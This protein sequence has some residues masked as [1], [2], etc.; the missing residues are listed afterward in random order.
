MPLTRWLRFY[1]H[2]CPDLSRVIKLARFPVGHP[3][4]SVWCGHPW[5]VAL[6]QS[7][8]RREFQKVGHRG[9]HKVRMRR[10]AVTPAIDV[11]LHDPARV[12][13]VVTIETGAMICVLTDD[14]KATNWSPVSF[15]AAWYPRRR[16][17]I[18]P[19]VEIGFLLPQAHDD[20]WPAGMTLRE[21]RRD[22]VVH[23]TTAAQGHEG[24]AERTKLRKSIHHW[25]RPS[26]CFFSKNSWPRLVACQSL[27]GTTSRQNCSLS[28]SNRIGHYLACRSRSASIDALGFSNHD[29]F[30]PSPDRAR[31]R[32]DCRTVI[33][34]TASMSLTIPERRGLLADR[35]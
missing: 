14:L 17:S 15:S 26:A 27:T 13:N 8:A 25:L 10:S 18:I 35:V 2:W 6:V 29:G 32:F 9:A 19:A 3:N 21:V 33:D 28:P 30:P 24:R 16:S 20:R 22:Q 7:V 4:A 1:D 23:S 34:F 11:G 5:Q 12:I 31:L